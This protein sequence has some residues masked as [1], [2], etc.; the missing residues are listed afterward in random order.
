MPKAW[1]SWSEKLWHREKYDVQILVSSWVNL[2][3]PVLC[4]GTENGVTSFHTCVCVLENHTMYRERETDKQT[5]RQRVRDRERQSEEDSEGER[6]V[7][8]QNERDGERGR[9][10]EGHRGGNGRERERGGGGWREGCV[11]EQ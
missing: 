8:T 2:S 6:G 5:D 7:G 3:S 9:E 1:D 4:Q 11:H 10:R